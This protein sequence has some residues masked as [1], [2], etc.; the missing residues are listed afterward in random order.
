MVISA[1]GRAWA[2]GGSWPAGR[3]QGCLSRAGGGLP[4]WPSTGPQDLGLVRVALGTLGLL[5]IRGRGWGWPG[6]PGPRGQLPPSSGMQRLVSEG[7]ERSCPPRGAHWAPCRW[8]PPPGPEPGGGA[9]GPSPYRTPT[10]PAPELLPASLNWQPPSSCPWPGTPHACP[11]RPWLMEQVCGRERWGRWGLGGQGLGGVFW[12]WAECLE[13]VLGV[14]RPG[15]R[16][17][18]EARRSTSSWP[19]GPGSRPPWLTGQRV[20]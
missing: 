19:L 5:G 4:R 18:L 6:A 20:R 12:E 17:A 3:T 14:P 7:G 2:C 16:E 10:S 15:V 1:A 11:S 8:A 9:P 13:E